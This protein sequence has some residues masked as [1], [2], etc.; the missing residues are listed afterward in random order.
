MSGSHVS[1]GQRSGHHMHVDHIQQSSM[2]ASSHS[3]RNGAARSQHADHAGDSTI[4]SQDRVPSRHSHA[5]TADV[6]H[7][8]YANMG[9]A[10]AHGMRRPPSAPL[11]LPPHMHVYGVG[12]HANNELLES[13]SPLHG[14]GGR[15]ATGPGPACVDYP[16]DRE[17]MGQ[18]KDRQ[19]RL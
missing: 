5:E 16:R 9:P 13:A 15:P 14:G 11:Q 3:T 19:A 4:T 6:M 18:L 10:V 1:V 8:A 7:G 17:N 2:S 12:G